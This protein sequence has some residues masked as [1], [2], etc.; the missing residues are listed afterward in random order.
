MKQEVGQLKRIVITMCCILIYLFSIHTH[1]H[2]IEIENETTFVLC[3][4]YWNHRT[5]A[6]HT[7]DFWHA[8]QTNGLWPV[9][10][11]NF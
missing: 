9:K 3:E 6:C 8:T 1:F 2:V 10:P 5:L 11:S 7:I 4:S